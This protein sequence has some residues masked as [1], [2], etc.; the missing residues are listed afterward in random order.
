M[1]KPPSDAL[2]DAIA[3]A[4]QRHGAH[5]SWIEICMALG[6]SLDCALRANPDWAQRSA[7]AGHIAQNLVTDPMETRH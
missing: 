6:W 2:F 3:R 1:T 4:V 5:C 7:V